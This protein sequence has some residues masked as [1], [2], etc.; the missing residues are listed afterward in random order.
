MLN[1]FHLVGAAAM[2]TRCRAISLIET[3]IT[4]SITALV[5]SIG[6]PSLAN[7]MH[8]T[9]L[10]NSASELVAALQGARAEAM[11]R[12]Q[13]VRITL[14]DATGHAV[15]TMGCVA[16]SAGCPPELRRVA[17]ASESLARWGASTVAVTTAATSALSVPLTAGQNLPAQVTF[18]GLG[19]APAVGSGSEVARIDVTHA[20]DTTEAITRRLV[21]LLTSNGMVRLCDPLIAT[22][23]AQSC[24]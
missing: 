24:S 10:R 7:W 15:W 6:M 19:A 16:I 13:D 22:G 20:A 2:R 5:F 12:N 14:G 8:A 3:L 17:T 11:A 21:V 1:R 9:E 4:L 18:N 23:R